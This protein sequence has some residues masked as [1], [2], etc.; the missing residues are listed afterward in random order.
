MLY[1]NNQSHPSFPTATH[2]K[3]HTFLIPHI[4]QTYIHTH[5]HSYTQQPA[6]THSRMRQHYT[7]PFRRSHRAN[8][9]GPPNLHAGQNSPV[10]RQR[11]F[12][13][14]HKRP[15]SHLLP[16][17]LKYAHTRQHTQAHAHTCFHTPTHLSTRP[18]V[19][20]HAHT[21]FHTPTRAFTRPH[22]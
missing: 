5:T 12:K 22:T 20:S 10:L 3:K 11:I 2:Y 8:G 18:H 17:R 9:H 4:L 6:I 1:L 13:I 15:H 7:V 21:C 16:H 14:F 19:L